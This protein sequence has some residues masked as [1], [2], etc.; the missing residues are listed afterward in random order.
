MNITLDNILNLHQSCKLE[1][2]SK[3]NKQMLIVQYEQCKQ[4]SDL[5]KEIK[6]SNAVSI[7]I[8]ENQ[9]KEA[10]HKETLKYYKSQIGR[11][12]CRERV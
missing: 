4:I 6:Q 3:I 5:N 12:S 9:L 1:D 10:K 2:I 8:L 7:Q 11:A